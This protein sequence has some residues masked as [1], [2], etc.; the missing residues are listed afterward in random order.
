M[1]GYNLDEEDGLVGGIQ[2]HDVGPYQQFPLTALVIEL[3][4]LAPFSPLNFSQLVEVDVALSFYF[5]RTHG[6]CLGQ[7][8]HLA[9]VVRGVGSIHVG[10]LHLLDAQQYLL[11]LGMAVA[12]V[13]V[14]ALLLRLFVR[15]QMRE[16]RLVVLAFAS[17]YLSPTAN[18]SVSLK[19]SLRISNVNLLVVGSE[20][21][22]TF[23]GHCRR[24]E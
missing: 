10:H 23:Y 19:L 16:M 15:S 13:G 11:S 1:R 20:R 7:P 12:F 2:K 17:Y 5:H 24:L 8:G 18:A 3:I 14:G 21:E 9:R 4:G 22:I 6:P